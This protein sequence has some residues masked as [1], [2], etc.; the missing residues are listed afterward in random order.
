MP[1][2]YFQHAHPLWYLPCDGGLLYL[3][4]VTFWPHRMP[5]HYFSYFGQFSKYLAFN[6]HPLLLGIF[7]MAMFLHVY[8]TLI[9]YRLCRTLN[10]DR[11]CTW[12][13]IV[14]TLLLG[15][16]SLSLLKRYEQWKRH[17]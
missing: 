13:W 14:Q 5:Y 3:T 16:P 1:E 4:I 8:E 6:Y 2:D 9:A 17:R 15:Y 10:L 12:R 7:V 11:Q